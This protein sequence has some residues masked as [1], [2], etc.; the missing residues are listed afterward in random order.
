MSPPLPST[1]Q[2]I[3][4]PTPYPVGRV[5]AYLLGAETAGL[6]DT[7]VRSDISFTRLFEELGGEDSLKR[8]DG[9]ALTHRHYDH[10]GAAPDLARRG[11]TP[12]RCHADSLIDEVRGR[13]TFMALISRFGAPEDTT[14]KLE[15]TWA[16]GD[17]FGEDLRAAPGLRLLEDGERFVF[18]GQTLLAL[19]TPG[20]SPG[21][22]CFLAEELGVLFCGDLLLA[23][24]TANP[25]PHFD[26]DAPRGR[27]S[28]LT[29]YLDS[30]ARIE[31]LGSLVGLPGH[32]QPLPD[33]AAAAATAQ[34]HILARNKKVLR[35]VQRF[36]GRSLFDL[37][38]KFFWEESVVGQALAFCEL[39]AHVDLLSDLGDV[40]LEPD[41]GIVRL[42]SRAQTD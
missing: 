10:A 35:L 39:L 29:L 6:I 1:I 17:H 37:A 5:N 15:Q 40:T 24:I 11:V 23:D 31:T 42:T 14:A 18:G 2:T 38:K 41:R 26:D 32:G 4:L 12:L 33:T 27:L 36:E 19:A 25:L 28:S 34:R 8:L 22:L 16:H 7:G 3:S 21:H 20:H 9:I 13:R 30:L